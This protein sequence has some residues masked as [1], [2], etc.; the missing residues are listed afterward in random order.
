[1]FVQPLFIEFRK[2][3]CIFRKKCAFS[4]INFK[5]IFT[6][7]YF[8]ICLINKN[9]IFNYGRKWGRGL[10][11]HKVF[12]KFGTVPTFGYRILIVEKS[13]EPKFYWQLIVGSTKI[14]TILISFRMSHVL[15]YTA[16]Y[17]YC[18]RTYGYTYIYSTY[19]N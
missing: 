11:V 12:S 6:P 13:L 8:Y 17:L 15:V 2:V 16:L 5:I 1:M 18:I 3:W 19:R 9:T 7:Y 4:N 14:L 10:V